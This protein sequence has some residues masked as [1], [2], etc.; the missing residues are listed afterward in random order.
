M[1]VCLSP[2]TSGSYVKRGRNEEDI[3]L[4]WLILVS[5]GPVLIRQIPCRV[6]LPCIAI[7]N[8]HEALNTAAAAP[9]AAAATSVTEDSRPEDLAL[10]PRISSSSTV[11]PGGQRSHS[12][13]YILTFNKILAFILRTDVVELDVGLPGSWVRVL[14][15]I[16]S[17]EVCP[18]NVARELV[19]GLKEVFSVLDAKSQDQ[20]TQR[21]QKARIHLGKLHNRFKE[22]STMETAEMNENMKISIRASLMIWRKSL[23][24][25]FNRLICGLISQDEESTL[26]HAF[27]IN[28]LLNEF[29]SDRFLSGG[30]DE[31]PLAVLTGIDHLHQY[32]QTYKAGITEVLFQWTASL[33][34]QTKSFSQQILIKKLQQQAKRI[35]LPEESIKLSKFLYKQ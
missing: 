28:F 15:G 18:L 26:E 2:Y 17:E 35:L 6:M 23:V 13:K 30:T 9:S 11:Q 27:L 21:K 34:Q 12:W 19:S 16:V 1:D 33:S 8:V 7:Q 25:L 10:Y 14:N 22:L 4:A 3:L 24:G 29:R 20:F 31:L 32:I 5:I